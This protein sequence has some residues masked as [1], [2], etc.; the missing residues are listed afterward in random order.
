MPSK[1]QISINWREDA[2]NWFDSM[3]AAGLSDMTIRTRRQQIMVMSNGLKKS[4]LDVTGQ[5]LVTWFAGRKWKPETRKG[6]RNA[7]SS[8]FGWLKQTGRR[9]DDPSELLPSVRRP[10]VH[11]HPC[12]DRIILAALGKANKTETMMI[13]LGAECGLRRAEIAQVNAADVMDDL[14]GHSLI[15]HGKGDKQRIVPLPD[16]LAD[17]IT[18]HGGWLFPGRWTGHVEPS[19][20]SKHVTRLLGDGWS[21]HSLRH[22]YATKTY[23]STH[24]LYVVAKLLGHE[25]VETTQ[26]YVAMPDSRL[27]S[28]MHDVQLVS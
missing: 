22:R 15:V 24:D 1:K 11:P 23:E 12:P 25:S 8:F 18:Q 14:L 20:V 6:Y 10:A 5:R 2:A 13:R 26:R 7:A 4:P 19:Y 27:R 21:T 3:K 16:D 17:Q 28:A 9:P